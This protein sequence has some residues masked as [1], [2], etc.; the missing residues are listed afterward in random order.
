MDQV[1]DHDESDTEDVNT[2]VN[3]PGAPCV[4]ITQDTWS[5]HC[6]QVDDYVYSDTEDEDFEDDQPHRTDT[7]DKDFDFDFEE[8]MGTCKG[9]GTD[10]LIDEDFQQIIAEFGVSNFHSCVTT[11]PIVITS[12]FSRRTVRRGS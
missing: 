3:E 9:L 10:D 2:T 8:E 4:N 5:G 11:T 12:P 6:A 1:E 7:S